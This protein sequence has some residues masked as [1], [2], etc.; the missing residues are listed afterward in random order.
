MVSD[1][2]RTCPWLGNEALLSTPITGTYIDG[3][4][5]GTSWA[6]IGEPQ[7]YQGSLMFIS[8]TT[9]SNVTGGIGIIWSEPNQPATGYM[10]SGFADF[11]NLIQT[12]NS[13]LYALKATNS[14]LYYSRAGSWGVLSGTPSVNFQNTATQDVVSYNVGCVSSKSVKAFR[15]ITS[16]SAIRSV[17]RG[18]FAI[19]RKPWNR[20][21][22]NAA[23]LR[24]ADCKRDES[25]HGHGVCVGRDRTESQ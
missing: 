15:L 11:W 8:A 21:A 25:E 22:E 23:V 13:Q 9:F 5:S 18:G 17:V 1:G 2:S 20:L 16:I 6:A 19:W 10:Q 4:G 12:G 3:D 7:I 14:G 24:V